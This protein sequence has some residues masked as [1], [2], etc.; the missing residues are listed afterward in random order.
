MHF[1]KRNASHE[2]VHISFI[3]RTY[4]NWDIMAL[5]LRW[6]LVMRNVMT[7]H[8]HS[9]AQTKTSRT[10]GRKSHRRHDVFNRNFF[11]NEFELN[12]R[13][14]QSTGSTSN[15]IVCLC[16]MYDCTC[17]TSHTSHHLLCGSLNSESIRS[18]QKWTIERVRWT[19]HVSPFRFIYHCR[20]MPMDGT[21]GI[22]IL[23]FVTEIEKWRKEVLI[24]RSQELNWIN[25]EK[26]VVIFLFPFTD[27]ISFF[28][29]LVVLLSDESICTRRSE[30]EVKWL[31]LQQFSI[32]ISRFLFIHFANQKQLRRNVFD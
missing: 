15:E 17:A 10:N 6:Q 8:L 31:R 9:A 2:K 27:R 3:S 14:R 12:G 28:R 4:W 21:R 23:F 24:A 13:R 25:R 22:S 16:S 19:V 18:A 1:A 5:T 30:G 7:L 20:L 32:A 11:V 29:R 26:I